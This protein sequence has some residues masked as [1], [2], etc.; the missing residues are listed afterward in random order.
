MAGF[1]LMEL[2][3]VLVIISIGVATAVIALRP[4]TARL[5]QDEGERLSIL[6]GLAG[7]E[8][9]AGGATLAWVG[10][11]GGYEFQSRQITDLGPDW[12]VVRGDDLL[13]P[14]QL[15]EGLYIRSIR[16]DGR[17]LA[18]GERVELGGR[19]KHDL[20]IVLGRGDMVIRVSGNSDRFVANELVANEIGANEIG[21]NVAAG[22]DS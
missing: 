16:V 6:L 8:S 19:M 17:D 20:A 15:P 3:V 11:E 22:N 5:V 18:F 10:Y 21:A 7:E 4:D 14:R 12:M 9:Q 13:H 2:L 1:T